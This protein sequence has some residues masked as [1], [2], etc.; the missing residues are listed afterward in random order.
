MKKCCNTANV[1]NCTGQVLPYLQ[2]C[3]CLLN[4]QCIAAFT[5]KQPPVVEIVGMPVYKRPATSVGRLMQRPASK[6]NAKV[7]TPAQLPLLKQCSICHGHLLSRTDEAAI[8]CTIVGSESF[9]T[10]ATYRKICSGKTCRATHRANFAYQDGVKVNTLSFNDL[11]KN[12]IYLVSSKFGFTMQYL[13]MTF[14]RFLRGNLAPGQ[15]TSVRGI[16]AEEGDPPI[17]PQRFQNYLMIALEGFAL[18]RRSPEKIVPFHLD[19][20]SSYLKFDHVPF[21]FPPPSKVTA[22]S[23][24]GHF[25]I[26]RKLHLD[27][28]PPRTVALRG[29]PRK[30]KYSREDRTCTCA[31]KDKVRLYSK[32]RTAGWQFVID[33]H[34]RH[35]VAAHE[36]IVN[37]SLKDKVE[38]IMAAM[39]LPKVKPDL[40]IHDDACHFEAHI[41]KKCKS[42]KRMIRAFKSIKY[43]VVDEFHRVNHK[44]AKKKL[45]TREK[46][47]MKRVRT[48]MSEVFNAW[49][50]RKN[51]VLN[52]MNCY[53]HRFWMQEAIT[54]WNANLGNLPKYITKRSTATTRKRKNTKA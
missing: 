31:N 10:M 17:H 29:R 52:S 19:R 41:K 25:G 24:D 7:N 13:K 49:I 36:H 27:Y 11:E 43:Y 32:N 20:P 21:L 5:L 22:L 8:E 35:V 2:I 28:E 34:S 15:E 18:A 9:Q 48:N 40:L 46:T 51:F 6:K 26:H 16:L 42:C 30:N 23:F 37:E 1:C 33:P 12:G 45:T 54:F 4:L 3:I 53:S 39:T 14:Y 38:T 44:C 47:R 50:R